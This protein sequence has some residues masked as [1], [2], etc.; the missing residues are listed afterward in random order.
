MPVV[1]RFRL[2]LAEKAQKGRRNIPLT[3][4]ERETNISWKTLQ[5]WANNQVTRYDAPVIEA[6]CEFLDCEVGDLIIYERD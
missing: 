4:V 3:E 2:L 5:G 1:N 6:L